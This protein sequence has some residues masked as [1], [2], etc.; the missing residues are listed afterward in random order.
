MGQVQPRAVEAAR[1]AGRPEKEVERLFVLVDDDPLVL[2]NTA[3]M[4]KD[5]GH[6]VIEAGSGQQVLDLL[7]SG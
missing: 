7:R 4:L 5:L 2:A 3:A 1:D 6:W